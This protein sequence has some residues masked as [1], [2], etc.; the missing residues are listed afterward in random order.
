MQKSFE[1]NEIYDIM[2]LLPFGI[3][4]INNKYEVITHNIK[5]QHYLK[6]TDNEE[7]NILLNLD[8]LLERYRITKY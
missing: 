6:L 5:L 1:N 2:N 3:C 7:R 8:S 4:L